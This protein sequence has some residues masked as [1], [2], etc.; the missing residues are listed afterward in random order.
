MYRVYYRRFFIEQY[1]Q[2]ILAI[3]EEYQKK[4]LERTDLTEQERKV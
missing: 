4:I 3:E 1:T 2:R